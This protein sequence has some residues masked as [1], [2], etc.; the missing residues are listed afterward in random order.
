MVKIVCVDIEI[1]KE[2]YVNILYICIYF[3]VREDWG[4]K[5]FYGYQNKG[6]KNRRKNYFNWRYFRFDRIVH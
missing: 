6:Y 3:V 2:K 4:E 1:F 5:I